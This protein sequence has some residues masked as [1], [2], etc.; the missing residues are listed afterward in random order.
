VLRLYI[1]GRRT[2]AG[3][4]GT[5][6]VERART[7][8][9][10]HGADL[11]QGPVDCRPVGSQY[12]SRSESG[13][14]S[15]S[16]LDLGPDQDS[17]PASNPDT[18]CDPNCDPDSDP[19]SNPHSDPTPTRTP[20]RT[21][22]RTSTLTPTRT[23]TWISTRI[24]TR[25]PTPTRSLFTATGHVTRTADLRQGPVDCRHGC[26][27]GASGAHLPQSGELFRTLRHDLRR[28]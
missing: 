2:R 4:F 10:K 22:S 15:G 12:R 6:S 17:D 14:E 25:T 16:T 21:P 23:P 28:H 13:W 18:D 9:S 20:T 1:D 7:A 19:D 3:Q 27:H 26:G 8:Q 11:R 5:S 24:P